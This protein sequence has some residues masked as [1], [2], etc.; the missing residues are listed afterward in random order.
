MTEKHIAWLFL[1]SLLALAEPANATEM[2]K[3]LLGT[4]CWD[5][6]NIYFRS[7]NGKADGCE[8]IT[9]VI[10]PNGYERSE[11]AFCRFA[12][13]TEERSPQA[14]AI[15]KVDARCPWGK[16][17]MTLMFARGFLTVRGRP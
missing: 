15:A 13:I 14:I 2:P 9:L 3:E 6:G 8:S 17:T 16:R 1:A 5:N 4:W 12:K 11:S 7:S 10:G